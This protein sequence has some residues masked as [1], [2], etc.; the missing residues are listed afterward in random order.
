MNPIPFLEALK[1]SDFSLSIQYSAWAFP[2]IESVH[3]VAITLVFG[4]IAIVD[5]RLLGVASVSRRLSEVSRDCLVLTWVFFALAVVTGLLMFVTNAPIYFENT[6]FRWK[7]LF[8]ALAG[9]NMLVFEL[10]TV[11][12]SADWDD[13]STSVPAAGKLAGLLSITFWFAVI[14]CGRMIGFTLY[15]LPF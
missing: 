10:I 8:I 4:I 6:W 9:V 7:M 12:G 5:L 2:V 11:R 13:G 3:V 1:A 14:L 15:Q